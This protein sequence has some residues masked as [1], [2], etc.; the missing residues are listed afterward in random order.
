MNCKYKWWEKEAQEHIALK[1]THLMSH[2]AKT[3]GAPRVS[4]LLS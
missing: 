2:F 3:V 1:W 4:T